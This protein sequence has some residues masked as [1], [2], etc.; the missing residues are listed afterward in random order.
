[1]WHNPTNIKSEVSLDGGKKTVDWRF[2]SCMQPIHLEVKYR[3]KDWKRVVDG[4][5]Y[6]TFLKSCFEDIADK[7]PVKKANELNIAGIT[8]LGSI[9]REVIDETSRFLDAHLTIDGVFIWANGTTDGSQPYHFRLKPGA[10]HAE[11][12]FKPPTHNHRGTVIYFSLP[13]KLKR[14]TGSDRLTG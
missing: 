8:L 13:E 2:E 3:H 1:L 5:R 12:C 7:F 4:P 6:A 14:L 10:R 11:L 9:D